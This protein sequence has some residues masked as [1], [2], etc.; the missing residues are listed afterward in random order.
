MKYTIDMIKHNDNK[1]EMVTLVYNDYLD[2]MLFGI[3]S[4]LN[5][6]PEIKLLNGKITSLMLKYNNTIFNIMLSDTKQ[7]DSDVSIRKKTELYHN[8][9]DNFYNGLI[10]NEHNVIL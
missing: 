2:K 5:Y 9:D 4:Q 10:C 6:T 1:V 8:V 3:I 7:N